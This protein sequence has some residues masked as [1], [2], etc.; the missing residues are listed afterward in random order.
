MRQKFSF[1]R[2]EK[3]R[4]GRSTPVGPNL[5]LDLSSE[6]IELSYSYRIGGG[7]LR[8]CSLRINCRR[9]QQKK[10][11]LSVLVT[12]DCQAAPR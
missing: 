4:R 11:S 12:L 9:E 8:N 3:Q 10:N 5:V 2:H 6:T 1:R 7:N